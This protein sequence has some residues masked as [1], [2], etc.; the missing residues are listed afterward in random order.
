MREFDVAIIGGGIM[1]AAAA[2]EAARKGARVALVDQSYLPNPR[3]ASTDHSKVFRFAYPDP[4][5]ARMAAEALGLW[6]ELQRET[7]ATL[8]TQTGLLM[9]GQSRPSVETETYEILRALGVEAL[10]L[11]REEAAERF[12]QFNPESFSYAVFDPTGGILHAESCVRALVELAR[13]RGAEVF[14]NKEASGIKS[15]GRG[16]ALEIVCAGGEA[17]ACRRLLVASGPW[18]RR[19][20]PELSGVLTTTRQDTLYFEPRESPTAREPRAADFGI[21]SFPIFISFDTGF[22]GFPIHHAGA[23]K[24]ANHNKGEPAG[25]ESLGEPVGEA[26]VS[27]CRDFFSR[28]IP[29]LARAH[30]RATRV[31]LYNNTPDDDFIIDWHPGVEGV[32]IATGFSGHG[33][34]F[35]PVIGRICAELLLSG[36]A[37]SDIDRFS[38]KRFK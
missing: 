18:T 11:G 2:C 6:G 38:L 25:P 28:H 13:K 10:M 32:L 16:G 33:F 22:Y 14:E 34:K 24:I 31:C 5:Y 21:G 19:L 4:L 30:V 20:M 29:G 7:G 35:G 15:G 37:P 26:S 12:P 17:V 9:L 1:G 36:R 8:L 27:E 3:A 23:M